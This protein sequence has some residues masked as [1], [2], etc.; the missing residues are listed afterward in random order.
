MKR[1]YY[2]DL[3][4]TG[5]RTPVG[6]DLILHE[7]PD[8]AAILLDGKRLAGIMMEAAAA[9]KSPLAFPIM[10]L[11]LEKVAM[12]GMMG[13]GG[14]VDSY[15]FDACPDDAAAAKFETNLRGSL[16]P[17]MQANVQAVAEIVKARKYLPIGMSIGPV[18]LMT[19]LLSD[20]I[21]PIYA[22]AS[23]VTAKEDEEIRTL[24]RVLEFSTQMVL[25][26]VRA[27][28]D[29]GAKAIFIAEPAAN[30]AYFSPMQMAKST[31]IWD[32][33]VMAT[34]RRVKALLNQHGVELIFHCCGELIDTM[35]KKFAELDPAILSLGASRKLWEDA[36]I[37][38]NTTVLYG[39][40]PTKKFYSDDA[41][42]QPQVVQTTCELIKNMRATGHPFILG[43]ECDVLS[44]PN[45]AGLIR[46]KVDLMLTCTCG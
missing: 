5:L 34:N 25:R 16:P 3:A 13:I 28:I 41:I 21:T 33:Y 31:E 12:L 37:V 7:K 1:Q 42:S 23:G 8:H 40:L 39:N 2:L 10:D 6:T 19:K 29:A 38:P 44:V 4:A 9:Y 35:V 15:H 46:K 20:P 11:M 24:E 32:R 43:S 14:N 22:A 27:Q 18:S 45:C 30:V 17:R 26:S 36:K